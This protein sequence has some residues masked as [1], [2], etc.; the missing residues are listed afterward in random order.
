MKNKKYVALY[1]EL[2]QQIL[3]GTY[4]A[5]DRL[6]S[7]RVMADRTG[8]SPIT[9]ATA[10][11]MLEDE[12]YLTARQR[13][14]YF[15]NA[16]EPLHHTVAFP[17]PRASRPSPDQDPL[18]AAAADFEASVWFKA[19]RKVLSERGDALFV[20][21]PSMGC[22]VLR[23]A[24]ADYLYRCRGITADPRCIVIGSG[25]EQ[26]YETV[27]KLLGRDK[28][29]GIEDPCY[30][31]IPSV[32][33]GMGVS[34]CCLPMGE[35]GIESRALRSAQFDVLHVTP[36]HSFPSGVTAT[37][38]KR[39]EYL[40]WAE[41][42]GHY[43][44]ED[45]FD[46]ELYMPGQPIDSLYFLDHSQSVIYLNTFSGS[47]SPALRLGYLILPPRLMERYRTTLDKFS[48][49]VPVADQYFL[50]EFIENGS[51]ERHLNRKR[52]RLR[53]SS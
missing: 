6:P 7:K 26:L 31:Q 47:L 3:G 39:Q 36:F 30:E 41:A 18:P 50:A 42:E 44:L 46:S 15:V 10:Y 12:G 11:A 23:N 27:V 13:S 8:T 33:G 43:I 17:S 52:R 29:F 14:G 4:R 2:K 48:C 5:G 19:V 22:A 40:R 21:A 24:I 25:A 16:V 34:V 20:K 35:G 9:V 49:S 45:D 37:I 32:Y 38:A 1:Q 51:F 53:G 28:I